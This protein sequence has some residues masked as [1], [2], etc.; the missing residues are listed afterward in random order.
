MNCSSMRRLSLMAATVVGTLPSWVSA[1]EPVRQPRPLHT[2]SIVAVDSATGQIGVAVQSHWFSVGG[3]VSWAEPGVGAVAT[4]SFID[5]S[6]GPR[7]LMLMRTGMTGPVALRALLASDPDSAVRQVAMIDAQ[8]RVATFTGARDVPEAGGRAGKGYAVQAN[9]MAKNTV[10][11]AMARAYESSTGD[12]AERML[13]AL[14]A[15]QKEGG[16]IRGQQS[17]ALVVVSGDRSTPP[18]ERVFD[19]RVEDSRDPLVE[20]RRLVRVARAY[21]QATAGDNFVTR[22]QIDSAVVAYAA[23]SRILPDSVVNGEL[24]FWLAT[25]LADKGRVDEAMP[26]FRRAFDQDRAWGTLLW[27]LP[28]VGLLSSDSATIARIIREAMPST[29]A[30][31]QGQ[32]QQAQQPGAADSAA[33][34]ATIERF[35]NAL[36]AGDSVTALSLLTDDVVIVESGGVESRADYR[37][38]HLPADIAFAQAVKSVRG[39]GRIGIRGDVAWVSS[40]STAKGTYRERPVNSATAELIVLSRTGGMWKISAVHWSSRNIRP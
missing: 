28:K 7:G 21:Q 17:A 39:Q 18:W 40:T 19:L 6:Y 2:Y 35:H 38:H 27:R 10:W 30:R 5:P 26:H 15:A 20:L 33:I 32:A 31:R 11:D 1:Q 12:L 37:A 8:G 34:V 3:V 25:T 23:A 14:E 29:P 22:N 4:Q 13:A 24:S 16:D 36:A 9:L